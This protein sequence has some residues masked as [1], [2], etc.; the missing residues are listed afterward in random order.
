MDVSKYLTDE[1]ITYIKNAIEEAN[2]N[3]VFFTGLIDEKMKVVSV[4]VGSRGNEHTV[5]V[6]FSDER[7]CH[8]LIHNH[9]GGNLTPSRADLS[10]AERAS[11]N[12]KGFYIINNEVNDIYS[13]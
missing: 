4:K 6:N 5:P 8:V 9:P 10:V 7:E 13:C 11:E 3:E 12:A 2:G 1:V